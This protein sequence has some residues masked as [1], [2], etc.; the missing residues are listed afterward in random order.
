[1]EVDVYRRL[2]RHLDNMPIAYPATESG[3][4]LRVLKHLFTPEEAEMALDLS[5]LPQSL[6]R[7]YRRAKKRGVSLADTEQTLDRMVG[8][9]AILGE[10][11]ASKGR[12]GKYY[13]KVPLAVGMFEFQVDRLTKEFV[14]DYRE[15]DEGPFGEAVATKK[16]S[17]LRAIPIR[18]SLRPE[19][20]VAT[21]DDVRRVIEASPGPFAVGNCVCRQKEDLLEE[22]CRLTDIR[23]TCIWLQEVAEMSIERGIGRPLSKD[24]VLKLT[25]KAEEVGLVLQ[26]ENA[27]EP[28]F[29]CCCC[30][31]CCG[32]LKGT[33]RYPRPAEYFH[34]NYFAHVD[35]ESCKGCGRCVKRC[36][37]AAVSVT[38]K[39]AVVNLYRCIGCGLCV[40]TCKAEAM[41][42]RKKEREA[43]PAKDH[44]ALYQRI[45]MERL[46]P[47]GTVKVMGKKMLGM[48]I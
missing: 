3:V 9:G 39:V 46:G 37:M 8:K 28:L 42:L 15:Y 7:V 33:M 1:M 21:Y 6:E 24:E 5:A 13:S 26:P 30:G 44:D 12:P 38:D 23:E 35:A 17:Q 32:I 10:Q 36:Q 29:I 22:P 34:T 11:L 19:H 40:T 2:Q 47:W 14:Q 45:M 20:H 48:K 16:T 43:V 31:C 18:Q 25:D 4:E 27:R 41:H